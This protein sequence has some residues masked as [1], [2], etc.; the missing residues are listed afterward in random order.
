VLSPVRTLLQTVQTHSAVLDLHFCPSDADVLAVANSTGAVEIW[1]LDVPD[2]RPERSH[3]LVSEIPPSPSRARLIDVSTADPTA[4]MVLSASRDTL[5]TS[6]A[7]EPTP[8]PHGVPSF[9]DC[10]L[11]ATQSTGEVSLQRPPASLWQHGHE[12]WTAAWELPGHGRTCGTDDALGF[13]SGGDDSA[14]RYHSPCRHAQARNSSE[15]WE[16]DEDVRTHG[17]GVTAILPLPPGRAS[18]GHERLVVTGSYDECVRVL[19]PA[20]RPSRRW[21]CLAE[22]R[23]DGGV[24][25]L[26]LLSEASSDASRTY[27][28]LASC[29]HAGAR[30]LR[31][32][33]TEAGEDF[34]IEVLARFEE[35]ESMCYGSDARQICTEA[36][37][38]GWIFVSTSFYD[39]RLC[40]W[41]VGIDKAEVATIPDTN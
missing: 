30:L 1:R 40:V 41:Q 26:K 35:H 38:A 22:R 36:Q 7:W 8:S 11:L 29:M 3:G 34:K 18:T 13:Y 20:P 6:V 25:R 17:A 39:K 10:P 31:I 28:V 23:L 15:S 24:W 19:V 21:K 37:G 32:S 33:S 27:T 14:V 2:T 16:Y 4:E 12:A 9:R 5:V